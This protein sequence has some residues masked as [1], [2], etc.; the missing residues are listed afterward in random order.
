MLSYEIFYV[1]YLFYSDGYQKV[2]NS[3]KI[4]TWIDQNP[5]TERSW[6]FFQLAGFIDA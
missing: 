6:F 3:M 4:S 5:W 1:K 2:Y